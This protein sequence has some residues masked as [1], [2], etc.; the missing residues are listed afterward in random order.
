MEIGGHLLL[1]LHV[2]TSSAQD[3]DVKTSVFLSMARSKNCAN[4]EN[5]R[6]PVAKW[7]VSLLKVPTVSCS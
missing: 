1:F 7:N 6:F 3:T 2:L 5:I 4:K